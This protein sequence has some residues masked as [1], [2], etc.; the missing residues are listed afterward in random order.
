MPE[1]ARKLGNS[2]KNFSPAWRISGFEVAF[3][4][5]LADLEL[6]HRAELRKRG[7]LDFSELL[8]RTRNLLRDS[9]MVRQ[10]VQERMGALLVMGH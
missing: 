8:I 6:R 1:I 2:A 7:A 3:R 5:L 9:P 10:E 4:A